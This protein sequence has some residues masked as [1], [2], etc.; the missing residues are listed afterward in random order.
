LSSNLFNCKIIG[1]SLVI[2]GLKPFKILSS[3][4]LNGGLT[5][6]EAIVNKQVSAM[7]QV[8]ECEEYLVEEMLKLGLN[9]QTAAGFLTAADVR[10]FAASHMRGE[11]LSVT[12]IATAGLSHPAIPGDHVVDDELNTINIFLLVEADLTDAAMVNAVQTVTEAKVHA[13]NTLGVKSLYSGE[14]ATGTT[15]D[16]TAICSWNIGG[17]LK[18]TGAATPLGKLI[19][20]TV[21]SAVSRSATKWLRR[22]S[23][24]GTTSL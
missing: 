7:F 23:N 21:F 18:F 22:Q 11:G 12:C 6:C 5:T 19:G 20:K 14:W 24:Q 9:P 8:E 16:A 10:D 13:L 3:A 17:K 2:Q 15:T 4:V 1:E